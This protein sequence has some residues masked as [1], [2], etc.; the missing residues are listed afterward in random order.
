MHMYVCVHTNAM[1]CMGRSE[2]NPWGL[3]L[4]LHVMWILGIEFRFGIKYPLCLLT[5]GFLIN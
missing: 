4:S 5:E 1:A 3:M 2:D